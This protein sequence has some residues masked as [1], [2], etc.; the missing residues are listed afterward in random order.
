MNIQIM[1]DIEAIVHK[2]LTDRKI[3]FTFQSSMLGGRYEMGG[4]VADFR[5]DESRIILRVHG[6][7]W[8]R[9][10]DKQATDSVQREL[11]ESDGWTVVDLWGSD[12]ENN[13][14]ET[15]S[16]ALRGEEVL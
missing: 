2:W 6:D 12:I 8:H 16:K 5:L 4:S 14:E 11:L 13:L 1:S 10:I 7:Y 9:P 15:L 3:E